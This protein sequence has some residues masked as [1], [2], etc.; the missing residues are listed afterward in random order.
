MQDFQFRCHVFRI[1]TCS[2]RLGCL[3]RLLCWFFQGSWFF[4]QCKHAEIARARLSPGPFILATFTNLVRR[5]I[6]SRPW[7]KI[8]SEDPSLHWFCHFQFCNI[9]II[10]CNEALGYCITRNRQATTANDF[11][12]IAA[13][14]IT[15][16][17]DSLM[18]GASSGMDTN[19]LFKGF[20]SWR[21]LLESVRWSSS[22]RLC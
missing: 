18:I 5:W 12:V 4:I 11:G 9:G 1:A 6:Q 2:R 8:W 21:I 22:T 3:C 17:G 7:E 10:S 14:I 20:Y 15:S 13:K 19:S 16:S